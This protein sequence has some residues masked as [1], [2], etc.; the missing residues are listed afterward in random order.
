MFEAS[1]DNFY[2]DKRLND[3]LENRCKKCC[4]E[5]GKEYHDKPKVKRRRMNLYYKRMYGITIDMYEQMFLQQLGVCAICGVPS[6]GKALAVDHDHTT[7][8]VR[9][10]LCH[11][12]NQA[13][14]LIED[15]IDILHAMEDYLNKE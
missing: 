1:H 14:G 7:G 6:M 13:L 2:R 5:A 10:L 11:N 15:S 9:G 8:E 12:C 4:Y 3:G